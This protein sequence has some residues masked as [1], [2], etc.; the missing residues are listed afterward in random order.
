[1]KKKAAAG[2]PSSSELGS[3]WLVV[4]APVDDRSGTQISCWSATTCQ[5]TATAEQRRSTGESRAMQGV[6]AAR[7]GRKMVEGDLYLPT[8]AAV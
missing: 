2:G 5:H 4:G 3:T 1:M 6:R 7:G 8:A